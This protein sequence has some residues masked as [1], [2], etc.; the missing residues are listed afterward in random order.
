MVPEFARTRVLIRNRRWLGDERGDPLQ[1]LLRRG[2][3]RLVGLVVHSGKC[4]EVDLVSARQLPQHVERAVRDPA[5]WRVGEALRQ[6]E[7][8]LLH[9]A[10]VR[11]VFARP[12]ASASSMYSMSV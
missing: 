2:T 6:H 1:R 5:V 11:A 4:D 8:P 7:E 3:G 9:T 12:A 10:S